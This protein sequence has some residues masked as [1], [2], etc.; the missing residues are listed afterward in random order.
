VIISAIVAVAKN[1][2]IGRH[3]Q[4]PW[5]L[6]ADLKYFKRTTLNHH[7]I[8]GSNS[9]HSIGRPLPM[10]T[11]IVISRNPFFVASGCLVAHS[12]EEALRLAEANGETE[13][14][15]IGGGQIYEKS[16]PC[17]DRLYLTEVDLEP[18]GDVFF[19]EIDRNEWREVFREAHLADEKNACN[20]TFLILEK[21][22]TLTGGDPPVSE[23][24]QNA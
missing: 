9:F 4:I 6:P 16:L 1:G 2:V 3:N 17:L 23:K 12:L 13:V 5:Y 11:N 19:P 21:K 14:F 10:R 18:E 24:N 8:M 7:I 20:Y 15:V 22:Q